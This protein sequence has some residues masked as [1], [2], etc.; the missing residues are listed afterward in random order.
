LAAQ[1]NY[2]R[3]G[4]A[5]YSTTYAGGN[6][7]PAALSSSYLYSADGLS[8]QVYG[9]TGYNNPTATYSSY[10]FGSGLPPPPPAYQASFLH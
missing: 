10:Q 1:N 3:R 2:D 5:A 7:S 8:S 4:H 9:S 6:R